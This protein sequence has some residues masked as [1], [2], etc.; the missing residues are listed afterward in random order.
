MLKNKSN[1]QESNLHK[2]LLF[3]LPC[4]TIFFSIYLCMCVCVC[5]CVF[6]QPLHHKQDVTQG[7]F[8]S[9]VL[10][11]W[12]QRFCSA[13]MVT[14]PK[15]RNTICLT[16]YL[17]LGREEMNLSLF[18]EHYHKGKFKQPHPRFELCMLSSFS[19]KMTLMPR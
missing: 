11:V 4:S 13:R 14:V 16:I 1:P 9:R 17:Y 12:I 18:P 3:E 2:I 6:T 7:Q 15:L 5:V 8:S 10:L 19:M